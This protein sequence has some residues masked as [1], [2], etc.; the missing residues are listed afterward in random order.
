MMDLL[1]EICKPF[2][3]LDFTGHGIMKF[4]SEFGLGVHIQKGVFSVS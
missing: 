3:K 4:L 2:L 1:R